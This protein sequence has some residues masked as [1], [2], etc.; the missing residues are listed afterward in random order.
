[1]LNLS[2]GGA[3]GELSTFCQ[4][5]TQIKA[6]PRGFPNILRSA[7]FYGILLNYGSIERGQPL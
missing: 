1:M 5:Q 6:D 7:Y 3:V 4:V 2:C